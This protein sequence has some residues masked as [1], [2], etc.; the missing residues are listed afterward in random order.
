MDLENIVIGLGA[1][2][3]VIIFRWIR[4]KKIRGIAQNV[5]LRNEQSAASL[6]SGQPYAYTILFFSVEIVDEQGNV[7]QLIPVELK[8]ERISG[9]VNNGHEVEV[10]GVKNYR[11]ILQPKHIRNLTTKAKVMASSPFTTL[12]LLWALIRGLF[13]LVQIVVIIPILLFVIWLLAW[14]FFF[15]AGF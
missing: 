2:L 4:R 13:F 15:N 7:V 11:G 8:G 10:I 14:N 3:I 6:L 5:D 9:F 1:F 12:G